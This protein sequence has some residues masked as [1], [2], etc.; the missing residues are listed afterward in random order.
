[1][2]IAAGLRVDRGGGVWYLINVTMSKPVNAQGKPNLYLIAG[3]NGAGKTTFAREFL[4]EY[5]N[6]RRFIN[7]DL[8]ASGL[9]PFDPAAVAAQAGKLVLREIRRAIRARESFAFESTLS[10]RTYLRLLK[11]A[12]SAGFRLHLVYLWIPGPE[13]ALVR[14]RDRVEAGGHDV[15][16]SDV[17]RRY[18]RSLRNLF[19]LYVSEMDLVHLLD[20]SGRF[21]RLVFRIENGITT[22][23]DMELYETIRNGL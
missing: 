2:K 4:P 19:M 1:M 7:P 6:C 15:P 23:V 9:S 12:K 11:E 3:S 13:L 22:V 16:E 8:I 5:V 14:I 10:G 21:P 20:N 17:R 18:T